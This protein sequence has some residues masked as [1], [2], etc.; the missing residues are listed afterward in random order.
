MNTSTIE[1]DAIAA[2]QHEGYVLL[3]DLISL[4][5][6]QALR[7]FVYAKLAEHHEV[8]R[9]Q[10]G[11]CLDDAEAVRAYVGSLIDRHARYHTLDKDM[12]HLVRG[13]FPIS[14]RLSEQIRMI[15]DEYPLIDV[16]EQLLGADA[17]RMHHPP[18]LRFKLPDQPQSNVPLHQDSS[19]N[20][21]LAKFVTVWLPL[22][23]I[24]GACGG[25][26]VL[27]GSHRLGRLDHE[28]QVIWG[29]YVDHKVSRRFSDRH[30]LMQL[31]DVL[32]FDPYTLHYSHSN[33]STTIRCS[34]DYR[35]FASTT[36]SPKH[37]FDLET[38]RVVSPA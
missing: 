20:E 18:M 22:C 2:Y 7:D 1:L 12:Q 36:D 13:E 9:K 19:Y 33:I 14:V 31:G 28:Q 21:H 15:I 8:F 32:L 4:Q 6:I 3:K 34:I 27:A 38:R 16:L 30:I 11:L 23:P 29:N 35:F 25:V 10:S 24:T 37:Y 26:N 17:L 5:T